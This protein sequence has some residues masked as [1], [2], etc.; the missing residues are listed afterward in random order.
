MKPWFFDCP[1]KFHEKLEQ[2]ALVQKRSKITAIRKKKISL[3]LSKPSIEV[4]EIVRTV[5]KKTASITTKPIREKSRF[6]FWWL[7][8]SLRERKK[9]L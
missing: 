1:A 6:S 3:R 5:R 2:F 8:I 9:Q 4:G 7:P